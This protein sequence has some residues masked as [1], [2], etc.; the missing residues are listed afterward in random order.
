MSSEHVL[1]YRMSDIVSRYGIS[2]SIV[3]RL[4]EAGNFPES[5]ALSARCVGWYKED[6]DKH[7]GIT[8]RAGAN[9][10]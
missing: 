7:F 9:D 1:V 2:R 3:Y 5:I 10:E 6:V 8:Q 4:I